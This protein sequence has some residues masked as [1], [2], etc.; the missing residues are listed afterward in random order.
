[1]KHLEYVSETLAKTLEKTLETTANIC[2]I[3]IKSLATYM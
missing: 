2:N 1:M 3:Q